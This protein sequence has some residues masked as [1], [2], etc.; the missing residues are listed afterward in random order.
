M[1]LMLMLILIAG[2]DADAVADADAD[3][4]AVADLLKVSLELPGKM[5][6]TS[7]RCRLVPIDVH[8]EGRGS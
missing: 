8:I 6:Q 2:A 4:D 7:M 5:R 1:I 3:A